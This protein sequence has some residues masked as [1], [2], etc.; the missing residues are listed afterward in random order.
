MIVSSVSRVA[1]VWIPLPRRGHTNAPSLPLSDCFSPA[2]F[3]RPGCRTRDRLSENA[4]RGAQSG[5][6][7]MRGALMSARYDM[8]AAEPDAGHLHTHVTLLQVNPGAAEIATL[9]DAGPRSNWRLA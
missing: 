1:R 6:P 7:L 4:V 2:V 5:A 8:E 9:A 3:A